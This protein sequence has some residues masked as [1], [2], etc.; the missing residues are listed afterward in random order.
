LSHAFRK[1]KTKNRNINN[2]F[3]FEADSR[4]LGV[5]LSLFYNLN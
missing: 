1:F 3:L 5:S 4:N 2:R